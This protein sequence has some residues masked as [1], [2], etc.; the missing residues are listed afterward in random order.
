MTPK[1]SSTAA[2]NPE[3]SFRGK[4]IKAKVLVGALAI[5]IAPVTLFGLAT[6]GI[7]R[8][9]ITEPTTDVGSQQAQDK[10]AI[11]NRLWLATIA[12][13]GGCAALLATRLLKEIS[14]SVSDSVHALQQIAQGDFEIQTNP[15]AAKE[16]IPLEVSVQQVTEQV[17]LML[18]AQK[19]SLA[20]EMNQ[21]LQQIQQQQNSEQSLQMELLDFL[22]SVEDAS[23]GNLTVRANITDGSVGIVAD[24][25]NSIVES[26]RDIVAQVKVA[27][28]QVNVSISG[29]ETA[30]EEVA[31]EALK[32]TEQISQALARVAE[33]TQSIQKVA[34]NAKQAAE[35]SRTASVTAETGGQAIE[36]T[37]S[38]ILDLRE[39]I[40]ST[41]KKVKRL[42]ESSQEISKVVSLINQIAMQTNLLAINA[43]IE[44]SR[45]GEEGRGFAVVAEEVGE[46]AIRSAEATQEIEEIVENIQEETQEVV[47]A[48]EV[49]TSQVVEGTRLVQNTKD[50]LDKIASV[51]QQIDLLL[52]SISRATISQAQTSQTVTQLMEDVAAVSQKTSNA[53]LDVSQSLE[54]T[55]KIARQLEASVDTFTV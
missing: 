4:S 44:A 52:Q 5:S 50:K 49:G 14:C 40:A 46:L 12:I 47:V 2:Q 18:Q 43:S 51:S 19:D 42:G 22:T 7:V 36:D 30:I 3:S 13:A 45:A 15:T 48:M 11:A 17:Q 23:T 21:Q 25:F 41:A 35:V 55:V 27:S 16:F 53:S 8:E 38:S 10:I 28:T 37:V 6:Q 20:E 39:T 24:F 54:N 29:N 33:M 31:Q 34:D 9:S 1:N 32:Q 26:L